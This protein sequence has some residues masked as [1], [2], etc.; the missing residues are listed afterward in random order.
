MLTWR[1]DCDAH[2]NHALLKCIDGICELVAVYPTR[3]A[4]EQGFK[5]NARY[6]HLEPT[7][8]VA[9]DAYPTL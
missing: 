2:G 8:H 4:A 1:I 3:E 9:P 5:D 6:G 7:P